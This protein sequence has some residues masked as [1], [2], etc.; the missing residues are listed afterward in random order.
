M[1][2]NDQ[3]DP[4]P[5]SGSGA[6]DEQAPAPE[7]LPAEEPEHPAEAESTAL[8][9]GMPI[10]PEE[11]GQLKRLADAPDEDEEEASPEKDNAEATQAIP[12]GVPMSPDEFRRLKR[13][14]MQPDTDEDPEHAAGQT[15]DDGSQDIETEEE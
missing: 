5:G 14:A 15:D 12:L 7:S 13:Q 11:Y 3:A 6:G 8:P 4:E 1:P 2:C 10:S 9:I